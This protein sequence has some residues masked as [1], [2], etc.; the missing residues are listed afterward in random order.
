MI[1]YVVMGMVLHKPL[2]GYDIKKE[3]EAGIGN[4]FKSSYGNL[5]PALKKLTDKGYLTLTEQTQVDR[6]KKYYMATELGKAAFIEWLTSP[7]DPGSVTVSL[8]TKIFFFGELSEDIRTQE[9]SKYELH[10]QQTLQ[11]LRE[12]EKQF[13]IPDMDSRHY[14]EMSTL[15]YGIMNAQSMI[16]FLKHIGE[17]KPLSEIVSQEEQ[18]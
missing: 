16:Q 5:Y 11:Q 18:Q 6:L 4:F 8:L 7:L 13:S 14:F 10:M 3:I 1:E 17:Q 15:Y 2:T 12:M 9:L